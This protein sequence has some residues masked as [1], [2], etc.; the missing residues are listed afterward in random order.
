MQHSKLTHS[1]T[2]RPY[3]LQAFRRVELSNKCLAFA[4]LCKKICKKSF[5]VFLAYLFHSLFAVRVV[6]HLKPFLHIITWQKQTIWRR[7]QI[8][9][10]AHFIK[11]YRDPAH[12]KPDF[13]KVL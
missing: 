2:T 10:N 3:T 4:N 1:K 6:E 9:S 5:S 13:G 8:Y 12:F 7:K 11:P